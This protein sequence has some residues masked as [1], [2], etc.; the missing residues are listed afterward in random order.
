MD[1]NNSIKEIADRIDSFINSDTIKKDEIASGIIEA[2]MM[3]DDYDDLILIEPALE[4]FAELA[5]SFEVCAPGRILTPDQDYLP[6]G[7]NKD[8]P[9]NI[10]L[11]KYFEDIVNRFEQIKKKYNC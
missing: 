11:E 4:E 2:T 5:A 7:C 1:I 9:D 8:T 6:P 3:R 10:F